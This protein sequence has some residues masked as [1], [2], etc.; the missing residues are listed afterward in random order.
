MM[1]AKNIKLTVILVL[2][3]AASIA[4]TFWK[5]Q[6]GPNF[7]SNLFALEDVNPVDRITMQGP[8]QQLEFKAFSQ[9]FLINDTYTLDQNLLTVLGAVLQQI[10]VQRPASEINQDELW[11]QLQQEGTLVSVYAGEQLLKTFWAGGDQK[12]SYYATPEGEVYLVGIPGYT[13]YISG[14]FELD[15]QE[16]RSKNIFQSTWRSILSLSFQDLKD[17]KNDFSIDYQ[18]PFFKI[19]GVQNMDSNR[20]VGYLQDLGLLRAISVIDTAL[21]SPPSVRISTTDV[22][23]NRNLD[24][25]L[26]ELDSMFIGQSEERFY[27]FSPQQIQ[28]FL[29]NKSYF[30]KSTGDEAQAP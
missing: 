30:A 11:Q 21:S 29:K 9:G 10:R 5:D 4:L 27:L 7:D 16:W 8:Q 2:L 6:G 13:D 18:D 20:V 28:P 26:Y 14:L 17:P 24:L 3:I 12:Q 22:N 23:P 19:D 1:N 25:L 15:V